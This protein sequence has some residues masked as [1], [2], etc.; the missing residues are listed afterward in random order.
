MSRHVLLNGKSVTSLDS[1]P[2]EAWVDLSSSRYSDTDYRSNVLSAKA[3]YEAV[4]FLFR[5]VELRANGTSRIPWAIM[6]GDEQVLHSSDTVVPEQLSSLAKIKQLI[7]LTSACLCL[8]PEA[9]WFREKNRARDVNLKWLSPLSVL[10]VWSETDGLTGFDRNLNGRTIRFTTD[11]VAYFP[12]PNPLHETL[13]GLPPAHAVMTAAGV[14]YSSDQF[15]AGFFSRGA[16][17]ATLLTVE[18]NPVP[19]EMERLEAW[20]K[21]FFRGVSSA[22]ETAAIRAGVTPVVV[23][24]GISELGNSELTKDKKEDIMVGMGIPISIVLSNV[25]TDATAG[26]DAFNFYDLTLIPAFQ[27]IVNHINEQL[28]EP[29]GMMMQIRQEEMGIFQAD[30]NERGRS[31]AHYVNAGV[32]LGDAMELLGVSLPAGRA[33]EEYNQI[34]ERTQALPTVEDDEPDDSDIPD[35]PEVEQ[36]KA[37]FRRWARNRRNPKP[38]QFRSEL[39]NDEDKYQILSDMAEKG[40]TQPVAQASPFR[41]GFDGHQYP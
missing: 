23:G 30:E 22:W 6:R 4:A 31:L 8:S 9:F 2:P 39:L 25:A 28:L 20:W 7:W 41:T 32:P 10:P 24:E 13:P 26:Q 17:K 37:T 5:C 18:G 11:D 14:V 34:Q 33:Y 40:A 15:S 27:V 38:S 19:T 36:E 29:Q 12:I 1:Y 16:I 35:T 21:R 3:L